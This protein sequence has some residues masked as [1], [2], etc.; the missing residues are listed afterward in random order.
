VQRFKLTFLNAGDNKLC[1]P[2]DLFAKVLTVLTDPSDEKNKVRGGTFTSSHLLHRYMQRFLYS[3]RDE[4]KKKHYPLR[5]I[6][7]QDILIVL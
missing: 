4:I 3:Y 6:E 2:R 5:H 1:I 7:P